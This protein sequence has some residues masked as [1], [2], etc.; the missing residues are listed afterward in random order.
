M[1]HRSQKVTIFQKP[2]MV[3]AIDSL[4]VSVTVK[5]ID[6]CDKQPSGCHWDVGWSE[7]VRLSCRFG[8]S[9][10]EIRWYGYHGVFVHV[11]TC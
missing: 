11:Q 9:G 10:G 6:N 7:G 3:R 2:H 5:S 8:V 1:S 4:P